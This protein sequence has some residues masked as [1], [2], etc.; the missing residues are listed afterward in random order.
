MC[1]KVIPLI[2]EF[3]KITQKFKRHRTLNLRTIKT[4]ACLI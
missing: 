4:Y 3:I 1:H 2:N